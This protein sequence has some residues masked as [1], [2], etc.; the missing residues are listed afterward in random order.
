VKHSCRFSTS[1]SLRRIVGKIRKVEAFTKRRER[2]RREPFPTGKI[3][4]LAWPFRYRCSSE[5]ERTFLAGRIRRY[6]FSRRR[7]KLNLPSRFSDLVDEVSNLGR[8]KVRL[9][10]YQVKPEISLECRLL[11]STFEYANRVLTRCIWRFS[12][13]ISEDCARR[14]DVHRL[15][16]RDW[17]RNARSLWPSSPSVSEL[18]AMTRSG[19]VPDPI[20]RCP[21]VALNPPTMRELSSDP[22]LATQIVAD[23]VVGIRSSIFVPRM[24]HPWFK[25][26]DGILFLTVRYSI[27]IGL[28]RFLLGEWKK[29]PF[30]LWLNAKCRLKHYLRITARNTSKTGG[31]RGGDSRRI[32]VSST[33]ESGEASRNS[34]S[35][36]ATTLLLEAPS[37]EI[38]LR[39]FRRTQY[40][41]LT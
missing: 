1:A 15:A 24:F 25:Y 9:L 8:G 12:G 20:M 31:A 4:D 39:N 41:K 10:I 28:V 18:I 33:V 37:V 16:S 35:S 7:G 32:D 6:V 5:E 3:F 19:K 17:P 11:Q 26:R 27:P 36:V 14:V 23:N 38:A 29:N 34:S 22:I 2:E 30:N 13:S 21:R 40:A